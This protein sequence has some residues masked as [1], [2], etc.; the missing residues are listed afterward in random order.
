MV[1]LGFNLKKNS[2]ARVERVNIGLKLERLGGGG[3]KL[4]KK[5]E[6]LILNTGLEPDDPPSRFKVATSQTL[7]LIIIIS[8]HLSQQPP[9]LH[10]VP[11]AATPIAAMSGR[12]LLANRCRH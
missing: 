9:P 6:S 1:I 5:D 2:K 12:R 4:V 3:T 11:L 10:L 8:R 7:T